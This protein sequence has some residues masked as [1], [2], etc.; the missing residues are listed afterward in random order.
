MKIGVID[1]IDGA[2]GAPDE[3]RLE[4]LSHAEAQGYA[5]VWVDVRPDLSAS[6]GR[7]L[8]A[9]AQI[10]ENSADARFPFLIIAVLLRIP[11]PM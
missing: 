7:S 5:A 4:R 10:A 11:L 9:A 6:A 2:D 8:F 1:G 3:A